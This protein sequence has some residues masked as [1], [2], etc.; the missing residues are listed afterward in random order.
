MLK[1]SILVVEDE[2]IVSKDIQQS[3]IKLGY[4]IS[5]ASSTGVDAL[6]LAETEEPDLV[7]MDI[8]LKGS[9]SG[10]EAAKQIHQKFAI[11]I[12]YLTAYAD[13]ITLKKARLAEPYGYIIKPFKEIDLQTSIEMAVYKNRKETERMQGFNQSNNF[14]LSGG[15]SFFIRTKG[16]VLKINISEVLYIE[17]LKDY[18]QIITKQEIYVIHSTMKDLE[19][20]LEFTPLIRIHRSYFV[21]MEK[22]NAIEQHH[23]LLEGTDVVVPIGP[24]YRQQLQQRLRVL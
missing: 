17:A 12:I 14:Q 11:P 15:G 24:H 9:M 21:H 23:I 3:L 18:A 5:G 8:M 20:K 2:A 10:I 6:S 22:I 7:L 16:T 19:K 4:T 1:T 13:E